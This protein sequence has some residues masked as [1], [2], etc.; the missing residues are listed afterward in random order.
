MA[1]WDAE[2]ARKKQDAALDKWAAAEGLPFPNEEAKNAYIYRAG[3]FRDAIQLKKAPD[4]VP[5]YV[6][7]TFA[8]IFM[9]GRT[10][11]QAMYEPEECG[12]AYLEFAQTYQPDG[13]GSPHLIGYGPA[14]EKLGYKTFKWPGYNLADDA[15]YQYV[16]EEWMTRSD[17]DALISDPSDFLMRTYIPK[18]FKNLAPLAN[19]AP[20]YGTAEMVTQS[21]WFVSL[22]TP[23]VQ[24]AYKVILDAAKDNFEW[25]QVMLK[26]NIQMALSGFPGYAGGA[27][28]APFDYIG[29]TLR[30]TT[31]LLMD[32]F[33]CPEKVEM[34]TERLV[35]PMLNWALSSVRA[36]G[37]PMVFIP[38]HK[39]ADGFMSLPQFERF[40]W[41][42]LKVLMRKLAE[43]GCVPCPFVEGAYNERLDYL[44]E[45]SDI[46]CVYWLDKTDMVEARKR[47]GGKVCLGGGFPVSTLLTGSPAKVKDETKK[48]L[49]LAMG[50]GGYIL[51]CGC[52][53]DEGKDDTMHTFFEAGREYGK[54]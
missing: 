12:K 26:Y 16:E 41:K 43:H 6:N 36:T 45:M 51:G 10:G 21:E 39:G 53:L 52:A 14:L 8:P 1:T 49:D 40:Y 2:A 11:K 13:V 19:T 4:R 50:D 48:L 25:F 47:L 15:P 44:E 29:D 7:V 42:T 28:I 9:T 37:N 33:R 23:E 18:V 35:M 20:L 17:Y 5:A 38:L 34:A 22:G 46:R 24:E 32:M 3:L 27:T 30:G 31:N 54:Y